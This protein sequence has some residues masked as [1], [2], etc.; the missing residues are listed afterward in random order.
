MT[1]VYGKTSYQVLINGVTG[2]M[3]GSRPWSWVKIALLVLVAIT[4]LVL[5]T[6]E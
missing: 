4:I 3:A 1:Y 2:R 6:S 5:L